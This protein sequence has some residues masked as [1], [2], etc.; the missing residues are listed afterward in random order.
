[1]NIKRRNTYYFLSPYCLNTHSNMLIGR[2]LRSNVPGNVKIRGGNLAISW[3]RSYFII[4]MNKIH[5]SRFS[6]LPLHAAS[7]FFP[8]Q[9]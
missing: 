7:E 9:N 2:T 6:L 5:V 8:L 1:M 4:E 3:G